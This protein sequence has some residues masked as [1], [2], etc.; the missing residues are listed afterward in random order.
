[1]VRSTSSPH[2]HPMLC[3]A[4]KFTLGA[5]DTVLNCCVP[6]GKRVVRLRPGLLLEVIIQ[7]WQ[8]PEADPDLLADYKMATARDLDDEAEEA[9]RAFKPNSSV[10]NLK[11]Y[12]WQMFKD[13]AAVTEQE[14]K[15]LVK[16]N[17][18]KDIVKTFP[19]M[20]VP[21]MGPGSN[22][23]TLY[24][25]DL[26]GLPPGKLASV[27]KMRLVY[28]SSATRS[29]THLAA[30]DQLIQSAGQRWFSHVADL[31]FAERPDMAKPG[32]GK[33]P[34]VEQLLDAHLAVTQQRE[35]LQQKK[36]GDGASVARDIDLGGDSQD[37]EQQ[38]APEAVSTSAG[39]L[40]KGMAAKSQLKA[41]EKV[42]LAR[43]GKAKATATPTADAEDKSTSKTKKQKLQDNL[44]S[45]EDEAL[46]EV[47]EEHLRVG[48]TSLKSLEALK[49]LEFLRGGPTPLKQLTGA[50]SGVPWCW[51]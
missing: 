20:A 48:G 43:K 7:L 37:N 41:L 23:T 39:S 34:T 12:G 3:Q 25:L 32:A 45:L 13:F 19:N 28:G 29:E 24:A 6:C 4:V 46:R 22:N 17:N 38:D 51:S 27:A 2:H 10:A 21:W 14:H 49:P 5:N 9:S 42:S 50:L 15:D 30:E 35:L 11:Q 16:G 8:V 18:P 26:E 31:N 33:A 40:P 1:M 47:A 44:Q 36:L